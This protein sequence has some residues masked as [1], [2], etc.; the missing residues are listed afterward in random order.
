MASTTK[1]MT[2]LL[3]IESGNADR[4]IVVPPA[5]VRIGESSSKLLVGESISVGNLLKGLLVG[6]GN[7]AA[8]A[9]ANGLGP[10]QATF[11][12]RMNERARELGLTNTHYANP[13]GLDQ[14]RH[15]SS[16]GDLITLARVA[17]RRPSFRSI[18]A[19]RRVSIPGPGGRGIRRLES[20]NTLLSLDLRADGI[21]TGHTAG[22]GYSLVAHATSAEL[23]VGLYYATIGAPSATV[24]ARDAKRMIDWGFAQFAHPTIIAVDTVVARVPIRDRDG[25]SVEAGVTRPLQVAVRVGRPLSA[26]IIAPP[27]LIGPV[28]VGTKIGEVQIR[29]G[30]RMLRRVAL[31]AKKAVAGP[32]ITDRL[33]SAIGAVT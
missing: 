32:G 24:R 19:N 16:A 8:V 25:V 20:E 21:K 23:G 2:G 22:A 6:S 7:D 9:L 29:S 17:M 27:D 30:N 18:V 1:V 11:V 4:L 15:Y 5:S 31:V 3:A 28:A 14:A 26:R 10:S 33:R 12:R 13:H